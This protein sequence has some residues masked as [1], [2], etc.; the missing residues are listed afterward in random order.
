MKRKSLVMVLAAAMTLGCCSVNVMADDGVT[1]QF[2]N[3]FTG[4]DGDVLREIV[5]RFNEE[6]EDGI[7]VE[8]DI[9]PSDTL[10]EKV[11]PALAANTAPAL[12]VLH[13]MEWP[14]YANADNLLP[15]DDF[16][17]TTGMDKDNF[18]QS[19]LASY[20]KDGTQ[21]AIPMEWYAQYLFYNKYLFEEA[22]IENPPTTWDELAEDASKITNPDKKVYGVGLAVSGAVPWFTS[23]MYSNGGAV[24]NEDGTASALDSEENLNTLKW[25]QN[26]VNNGDSPQGAT[27]AD[28]DNLMMANQLGMVVNGPWMVNGLNENG[29]NWGVAPIPSGSEKQ[30]AISE[31]TGYC[32]PKGTS[33]EQKAAAYKFIK[34]WCS[35]EIA[36]EW[37]TR[38]AFP[39]YLKSVEED[40]DIQSDDLIKT[41]SSVTEIGVP[42]G[43]G[44]SQAAEVNTNVLF[45]MIENV[46]AG[47][48]VETQ[49]K[50]A[51]S[52]IDEILAR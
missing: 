44:I 9:M 1:I 15:V 13:D 42:F 29:I 27:G 3:S 10:T 43:T 18:E 46:I 33:D 16:F 12:L 7:T 36:K 25:V 14:A 34:Y 32:I 28:L 4:T 20:A 26:I 41:F 45:P 47:E 50:D 40:A 22:G 35:D 30:T 49:L 51:S 48:D 23:V 31:L 24:F 39:P 2:W 19:A 21:Y 38:N 6:N 17:E 5:D 52:Q 8:M 11:A 37:S